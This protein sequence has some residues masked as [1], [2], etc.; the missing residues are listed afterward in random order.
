MQ[1]I[2]LFNENNCQNDTLLPYTK[3]AKLK[4]YYDELFQFSK[5]YQN[6]KI[7]GEHNIENNIKWEKRTCGSSKE[8]SNVYN[9]DIRNSYKIVSYSYRYD[10]SSIQYVFL[11]DKEL[12]QKMRNWR[13][14]FFYLLTQYYRKYTEEGL[15]PPDDIIKYTKMYQEKCDLYAQFLTECTIPSTD[16][17][18]DT[19]EK[20]LYTEFKS[21][22]IGLYENKPPN[23]KDFKEYMMSKKKQLISIRRKHFKVTI[24]RDNEE[25][26]D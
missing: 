8:S 2:K 24:V 25:E 23:F 19:E 11:K 4:N 9:D 20:E 7:L 14:A 15:S 10:K 26:D 12:S 1:V 6:C 13:E 3:I 17:K 18:E 16:K 21:W 5:T 22:Y